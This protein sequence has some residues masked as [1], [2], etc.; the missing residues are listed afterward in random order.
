MERR[1][2]LINSAASLGTLL[3]TGQTCVDDV[4]VSG[5]AGPTLSHFRRSVA[6][7]LTDPWQ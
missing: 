6:L 5:E 2:F 4:N 3:F 1:Q 7:W